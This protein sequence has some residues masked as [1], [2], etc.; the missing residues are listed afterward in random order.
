MPA[1]RL[2]VGGESGPGARPTNL[3]WVRSIR[4]Q[5][6][7]AGVPVFIKQLGRY[8]YETQPAEGRPQGADYAL[9]N[10]GAEHPQ[11]KWFR[12]WTLIHNGDRSDWYRYFHGRDRKGGNPEEW[13]ED[14][15]LHEWPEDKAETGG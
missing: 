8:A 9:A 10:L 4:D 7:V 15:R 11:R 12:G 2:P 5:C 13:P 3:A 6:Q 14:L 1:A